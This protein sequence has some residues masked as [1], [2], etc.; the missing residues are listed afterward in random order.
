MSAVTIVAPQL[1]AF[2]AAIGRTPQT[3]LKFMR[4]ELSRGVKRIRA[5][6]IRTKLQ[7]PPGIHGGQ[8][9]KGKNVSTFV[10]GKSLKELSARIG[11]SRILHVHEKGLT[12]KGKSGGLLYLKAKGTKRIV[13]V[14][15]QVVIPARLGFVTLVQRETPA[16][17][18]KV[19]DA[20]SRATQVELR[21]GLLGHG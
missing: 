20:G 9:A 12:I 6:F 7:G 14:V 18:R 1:P 8:L 17:L 4:T 3:Q 13:A 19:A 2:I 10:N 11:I 5:L 16:M 21:K 15:K